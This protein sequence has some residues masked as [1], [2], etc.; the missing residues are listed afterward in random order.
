MFGPQHNWLVTSTRSARG[1]SVRLVRTSL[2]TLAVGA[3]CLSCVLLPQGAMLA[4]LPAVAAPT[5]AKIE[6]TAEAEWPHVLLRLW[7]LV[8]RLLPTGN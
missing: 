5:A 6:Q 1:L 4:T 2:L 7:V 8:P 3:F